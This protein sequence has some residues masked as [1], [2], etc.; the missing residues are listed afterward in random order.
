MWK[1]IL[2]LL[3]KVWNNEHKWVCFRNKGPKIQWP[4]LLYK[5]CW[6]FWRF[7]TPFTILKI[8]P[9]TLHMFWLDADQRIFGRFGANFFVTWKM[10]QNPSL[11][12]IEIGGRFQNPYRRQS[13][14]HWIHQHT[15]CRLSSLN[16]P[17]NA[18][19]I[20]IWEA[21]LNLDQITLVSQ[22]T[23]AS[24]LLQLT[25]RTWRR[26]KCQHVNSEGFGLGGLDSSFFAE[27]QTGSKWQ[28]FLFQSETICT[29]VG[30]FCT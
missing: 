13:C 7:P 12:M 18:I 24:N 14:P 5:F 17:R 26:H 28:V 21:C 25:R 16:L 4:F 9:Y 30:F 23:L 11:N 8:P 10:H 19:W 1:L 3:A 20:Y 6:A 27:S 15:S 22:S 29:L 2:N